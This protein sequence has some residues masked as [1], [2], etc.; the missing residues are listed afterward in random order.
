MGAEARAGARPLAPYAIE[1]KRHDPSPGCRTCKTNERNVLQVK[2]GTR[3]RHDQGISV[4]TC[5]KDALGRPTTR[6]EASLKLPPPEPISMGFRLRASGWLSRGLEKTGHRSV[7]WSLSQRS[8]SPFLSRRPP[9]V[10]SV[11]VVRARPVWWSAAEVVT[12]RPAGIDGSR[13][14]WEEEELAMESLEEEAPLACLVGPTR[15]VDCVEI[16]REGPGP[17]SLGATPPRPARRLPA[18]RPESRGGRWDAA[19][20]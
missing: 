19:D 3:R 5:T 11:P 17:I 13:L 16:G 2:A 18:R 1:W 8:Q 14:R 7:S 4:C 12:A 9:R 10:R 20:S 6:A 15:P